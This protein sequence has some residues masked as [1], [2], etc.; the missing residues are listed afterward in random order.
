MPSVSSSTI[1]TVLGLAKPDINLLL[2]QNLTSRV[3]QTLIF[4]FYQ[5]YNFSPLNNTYT[6]G[7]AQTSNS[8]KI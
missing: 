1:K 8:S 5:I 6:M 4:E 7:I 3:V 2:I